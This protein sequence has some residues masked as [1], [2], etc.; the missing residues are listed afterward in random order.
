[1]VES[2]HAIAT[3]SYVDTLAEQALLEDM[4][5]E[6]KPAP[7]TDT[8]SLHY[9][10]K[11]PFR[12][13]PLRWGSRFGT[14]SEPSLFYAG[15]SLG[16][17]LA[18]S[19]YYQLVF[20]H[21]I[22]GEPPEDHLNTEHTVFTV[23]FQSEMAVALEQPPFSRYAA[24][25][26]HPTQYAATQTLGAAMRAAAVDAFS[27]TSARDPDKGLCAALFSPAPF[28]QSKPTGQASW[29]CETS[30]RVVSFKLAGDSTVHAYDLGAFLVDNQLPIPAT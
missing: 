11:P 27:Y 16:A 25:L 26:T 23:D 15:L 30:A 3:R 1:M 10:L 8:Q 14:A 20:W 5:E 7:P 4:L 21:S 24:S 17:T 13:P 2:Q 12:S 9:L 29:S 6:K 18:E 19:A 28:T 22:E